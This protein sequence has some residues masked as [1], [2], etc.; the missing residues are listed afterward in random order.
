M[1]QSRFNAMASSPVGLT[2]VAGILI[3]LVLGTSLPSSPRI[4]AILND[5]AHVPV[6]GTLALIAWRLIGRRWP[7][8]RSVVA[9]L[10]AFFITTALGGL[11]EII[12]AFIG[13]DASFGDLGRDMLGAGCALSGLA[14][15]DP[16]LWRTGSGRGRR[17]VVAVLGIGCGLWALYP[18]AEASLAYARRASAFPVL[19]QFS[20]PLDLY[21]FS[22]ASAVL[23][24]QPLPAQW[25]QGADQQSLRVAFKAGRWPGVTHEEP[26][27]DWRGFSGLAIDLTNPSAAPL[28]IMVRVH[29]RWHDQ[30]YQDRFNRAFE[31]APRSRQIIHIPL[32]DIQHGPVARELDLAHI[33]GVTVFTHGDAMAVGRS[34]YLTRLGLE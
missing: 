31:L 10:S 25:A 19:A 28:A 7:S 34:F 4:F 8:V 20:I 14:V 33:A 21:F 24:V 29:D 23:T 11:I 26:T 9:Y 22:S 6:F 5:T 18:I 1:T 13:R 15:F 27:P 2:A 17:G 30:R 16:R 32:A 3:A 12:Q